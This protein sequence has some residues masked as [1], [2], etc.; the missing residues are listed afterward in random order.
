MAP[1]NKTTEVA[2]EKL[3]ENTA[4][5]TFDYGEDVGAGFENQTEKDQA[6]PIFNV[7]Q[8]NSPVVAENK[9]DNARAGMFINT[10]TNKLY[11]ELIIVPACTDRVFVRYR[12]RDLG[13]GFRGRHAPTDAI[14]Q[15]AIAEAE[16]KGSAYG[17]LEVAGNPEEELT[18]TFE[19]YCIVVDDEGL[20]PGMFNFQ[21]T[22]IKQYKNW[23]TAIRQMTV[24]QP[25]GRKVA[26]PF[27]AHLTRIT[28]FF[29]KRDKG[30]FYN[31]KVSPY[32]GDLKKS[33]LTPNDDRYMAARS[34]KEFVQS[35][36]VKVDYAKA[37]GAEGTGENEEA[38]PF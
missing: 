21:S 36:A 7:L 34:L 33:L 14:V 20:V 9:I 6:L 10:A 31:V 1:K 2:L 26:P 16:R 35:G 32:D 17:R 4:M 3:P 11:K 13:G 8:A 25:N 15:E 18:E 12:K 29:D 37:D 24:L 23:N 27:F 5:Q 30:S 19:L 22:K 38:A 28:T